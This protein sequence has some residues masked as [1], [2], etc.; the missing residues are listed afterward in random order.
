ALAAQTNYVYLANSN[1]GLRI[2]DV[3]DPRNPVNVGYVGITKPGNS[4]YAVTAAGNYCYVGA[5]A[6]GL[7]IYDVADR[8][9]PI[10]VGSVNV[11]AVRGVAL[12]GNYVYLANDLNG[13]RIFLIVPQLCIA[14]T[15]TNTVLLTWPETLKAFRPQQNAGLGSA[16]WVTLTN[17]PRKAGAWSRVTLPRQRATCSIGSRRNDHVDQIPCLQSNGIE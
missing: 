13:L 16:D 11:G 15:G 14:P 2:Y 1:D 4:L 10:E 8:A 6:D 9:N 12:S 7:H 17:A 5:N 3:S